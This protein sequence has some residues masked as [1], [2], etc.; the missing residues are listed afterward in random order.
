MHEHL[1]AQ[2]VAHEFRP[3]RLG[4]AFDWM[5]LGG[6][7]GGL[8]CM[9]FGFL[10]LREE[11]VAPTYRIGDASGVDLPTQNAPQPDFSLVAPRGDGFVLNFSTAWQGA[12]TRNGQSSSLADLVAEGRARSSAVLAGAMELDIR[13]G[14]EIQVATGE[15]SFVV[16][17]VNKPRRQAVPLLAN[18]DSNALT[19]VAATAVVVGGF[20]LGLDTLHEDEKRLYGDIF[21]DSDRYSLIQTTPFEDAIAE[22]LEKE[23]I[24][25]DPGSTGT[26]MSGDEGLMGDK[27][28]TRPTGLFAMKNR[29]TAPA[30]AKEQVLTQARE[31]GIL[32]IL[33]SSDGGAFAELHAMNQFS[34]GL[35]DDDIYGGLLG[36][37]VAAASGGWGYGTRGMGPGGGCIGCENWGTI[38]TGTY[39][40]IGH[41]EGTGAKFGAGGGKGGMRGHKSSAPIL[42]IGIVKKSGGIDADIIRRRIHR[43]LSRIRHCYEK[44]LL[45]HSDLQGTVNTHFQISPAGKVQGVGAKGMGNQN[46]ESCVA[47]VIK[48][49]QFPK[50]LDGGYVN[51]TRYPF[52]FR[53]AGG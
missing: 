8:L 5:A 31:S 25:S 17:S 30:L 48:T 27:E 37:E 18:I 20:M 21:A 50:P 3:Q 14:E 11:K 28:S 35:D 15:Q 26:K 52:M 53:P 32:G 47:G 2:K 12:L 41:G 29:D 7:G 1:E 46:V 45:V 33:K 43:K 16:R 34:S 23:A 24:E 4:A 39:G 9:T 38:G 40:T 10:R 44:E 13:A 42:K 51:V 6:L 19:Y 49:I 36:S 22:E